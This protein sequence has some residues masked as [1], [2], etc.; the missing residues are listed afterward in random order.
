MSERTAFLS[1]TERERG[2]RAYQAHALFNGAGFTF[3]ADTTIALM[4]VGLGATNTQLGFLSSAIH[5]SGFVLP[6]VPVLFAGMN[7]ANVY[8][9]TWLARGLVCLFYFA[10]PFLN[11]GPGLTLLLGVYTAFSLTRAFGAAMA[12]PVQRALTTRATLGVLLARLSVRFNVSALGARIVGAAILRVPA[13]AGMAGLMVLEACGVVTN[14]ISALYLRRLGVRDRVER[15]GGAGVLSTFAANIRR[16]G[17]LNALLLHWTTILGGIMLS[18]VVPFLKRT[19]M[20]S[21]SRVFAY[22][23]GGTLSAIAAAQLV[24]PFA[25]RLGSATLLVLSYGAS[26]ALAMV[27]VFVPPSLALWWYVGLGAATV[28]CMSVGGLAVSRVLVS[29]MPESNRVGYTS[30]YSFAGA[31]V[32]LVG[33]LLGGVL[34][35]LGANVVLP[36]AHAYSFAFAAASALLLTAA[37]VGLRTRSSGEGT[38]RDA[39]GILLSPRNLRDFLDLYQLDTTRDPAKRESILAAIEQSDTDLATAEIGNRLKSPQTADRER[40]LKSL[41]SHPRP[42]L[43]SE[44]IA[45]ASDRHSYLRSTALFALGAYR[46]PETERALL[47][48]LDDPDPVVQSSAAKSLA[49]IGDTTTLVHVDERAQTPDLPV[50]CRINYAIALC[51][52]DPAGSH[53]ERLFAMAP[54]E[55]GY[56]GSQAVLST[57]ARFLEMAP[58]LSDFLHQE[59]IERGT[60]MAQ[61]LEEARELPEFLSFEPEG[62]ELY[63]AGYHPAVWTWCRDQLSSRRAR[64]SGP[65]LSLANAVRDWD[66]KRVDDTNTVACVYFTYQILKGR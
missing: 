19:A 22:T 31:L 45:E 54:P 5:L 55:L 56:R 35:D 59:N 10:V 63:Q 43:V 25:D 15:T 62:L 28:F 42:E 58:L 27:W 39:A 3:L 1:S 20:L 6:F 8:F 30:M 38:V 2:A 44:I 33:G 47:E 57:Y 32:A 52:M 48:A 16:P 66:L 60:G 24:T 41:F 4:A 21:D 46:T 50:I 23:I 12:G 34:T 18:F 51:L 64:L 7:I 26:A 9:Y 13:L 37:L 29:S 49:R 36:L 11:P 53:L 65:S 40:A 14:T 61:L 17:V